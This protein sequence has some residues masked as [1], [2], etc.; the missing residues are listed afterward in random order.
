MFE[1]KRKNNVNVRVILLAWR[2]GSSENYIIPRPSKFG[3]TSHDSL[4]V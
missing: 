4:D 3:T 2:D 1:K